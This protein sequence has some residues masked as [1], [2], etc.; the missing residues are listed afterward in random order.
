MANRLGLSRLVQ[1]TGSREAIYTNPAGLA[2]KIVE[3]D[4]D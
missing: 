1:M 3:A 4:C 2:V